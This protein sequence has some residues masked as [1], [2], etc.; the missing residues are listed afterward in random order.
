VVG[1]HAEKLRGG[2]ESGLAFASTLRFAKEKPRRLPPEASVL[3]LRLL[4]DPVGST[5]EDSTPL[6]Y[7][8]RD[9]GQEL[10]HRFGTNLALANAR[11]FASKVDS[12]QS[13]D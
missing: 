13:S 1:I 10:W 7:Y 8:D 3:V 12:N 11:C 5:E 6:D 9:H 4:L 2:W